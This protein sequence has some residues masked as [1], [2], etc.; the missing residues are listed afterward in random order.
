M[1]ATVSKEK[2]TLNSPS[3]NESPLQIPANKSALKPGDEEGCHD[4]PEC[5]EK[6]IQGLQA[7]DP[8]NQG[9]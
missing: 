2:L 1:T 5:E 7:E 8:G 4:K 6:E 3:G 9:A